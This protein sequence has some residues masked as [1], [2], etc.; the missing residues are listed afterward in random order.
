MHRRVVVKTL[1]TAFSLPVLE[2]LSPKKLAAFARQTRARF[3]P[4]RGESRYIFKTLDPLQN[5]T[6]SDIAELAIPQTDTPGAKDARVNE[7]IDL[8]LTEWFST[9]EREHFLKGLRALEMESRELT[10][11]SFV[12]CDRDQRFRLLEAQEAAAIASREELS[13]NELEWGTFPQSILKRH[14]FDIM[15]WLTLFG[16]FTSE[17]GMIEE[18]DYKI[19][20]ATYSGCVPLNP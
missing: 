11:K 16:Y 3:V 2:H 18:L 8:L 9:E 1:A 13:G 14:F 20:H 10:N 7:L 4:R 12:D 15:K 19:V 17:A 6:V 5:K